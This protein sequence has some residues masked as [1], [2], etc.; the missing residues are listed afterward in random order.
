[1]QLIEIVLIVL[2]SFAIIILATLFL[3]YFGY[4]AR[5]RLEKKSNS[6][7]EADSYNNDLTSE[8]DPSEI[9]SSISNQKKQ[10]EKFVVFNPGLTK[11]SND[12]SS[13]VK[14]HKPHKLFIK[15]Q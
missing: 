7:T 11:I 5:K 12:S 4:K 13:E 6:R 15:K 3:S 2:T 10:Q 14:R 9:P 8:N 1:M